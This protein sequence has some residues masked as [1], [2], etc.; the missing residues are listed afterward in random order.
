MDNYLVKMIE[1]LIEYFPEKYKNRDIIFGI[2]IFII[3]FYF[4]IKIYF[5]HR[6]NNFKIKTNNNTRV[7]IIFDE[8]KNN[9]KYFQYLLQDYIGII[10]KN[11]EM[12]YLMNNNFFAISK[13]LKIAHSKMKFVNGKYQQKFPFIISL[14]F[15]IITG[16]IIFL[17]ISY[18]LFIN[19]IKKYF[20]NEQFISITIIILP[21][22]I[23]FSIICYVNLIGFGSASFISKYKKED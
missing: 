10:L 18:I 8:Y 5:L 14:I 3:S 16:I 6:K 23:F 1:L 22:L 12:E 21:L 2:F 17:T 4:V 15:M 19:D 9:N 11:D 7:K 13:N 20:K